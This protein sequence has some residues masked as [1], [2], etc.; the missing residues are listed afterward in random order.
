MF[1]KIIKVL[2]IVSWIIGIYY[3]VSI[4]VFFWR[5]NTRYKEFVIALD[6]VI[7]EE[8]NGNGGRDIDISPQS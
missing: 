1:D 5:L 4:I 8:N 3:A 7:D 2:V 6:Q